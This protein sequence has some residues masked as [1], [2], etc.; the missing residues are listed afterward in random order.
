MHQERA[1]IRSLYALLSEPAQQPSAAATETIKTAAV[2]TI[3]NDASGL[4]FA[5]F[6]PT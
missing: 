2:E 4:T 5:D 1:A 6:T 3:D